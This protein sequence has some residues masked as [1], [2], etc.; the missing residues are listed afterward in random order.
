[1]APCA[2][3]PAIVSGAPQVI[4]ERESQGDGRSGSWVVP[5]PGCMLAAGHFA[6]IGVVVGGL[7][8]TL[9]DRAR[10]VGA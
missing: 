8:C 4:A 6:A 5:G 7:I 9:L 2:A 3:A 1:M 10:L